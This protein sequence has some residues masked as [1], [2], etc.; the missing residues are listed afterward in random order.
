MAIFNFL[1]NFFFISLAITFGL[2]LLLVYHFKERMSLVEK[3]SDTMNEII[4]NVVKEMKSLRLAMIQQRDNPFSI[5]PH[6]ISPVPIVN[7]T[8]V[9]Q[10]ETPSIVH[11]PFT[12]PHIEYSIK[13]YDN[14]TVNTSKIVVSDESDT[15]I[16]SD[17]ESES[18]TEAMESSSE[19]S[20]DEE[21]V[22][23]DGSDDDSVHLEIQEINDIPIHLDAE[24]EM[25][26]VDDISFNELQIENMDEQIQS[27]EFDNAFLPEV[28]IDIALPETKIDEPI[29]STSNTRMLVDLLEPKDPKREVYRKMNINQ[30]RTIAVSSG[31]TQDTSKMKKNELIKLLESLDDE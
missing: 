20:S 3:K 24:P 10:P 29:L 30:L 23:D 12:Q 19:S 25:N 17:S 31:L 18:N 22:S 4:T 21:S 26:N 28:K 14:H 11:I 2:L 16:D 7:S 6:Q 15:E 8:P 5:G 1:E 27:D 13:E 9:F